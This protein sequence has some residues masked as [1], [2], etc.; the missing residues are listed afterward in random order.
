MIKSGSGTTATPSWTKEQD[1][2]GTLAGCKPQLRRPDGG[3]EIPEAQL[4]ESQKHAELYKENNTTMLNQL[5]SLSVVTSSQAE[6]IK[7]SMEN[8]GAKDLYIQDLQ[9][10]MS[11]KDSLNMA[12]VMN[13]VLALLAT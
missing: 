11:R 9:K 12:L 4:Q 13:L 7:Q 3:Q 10:E 5:Q 6:S 1:H 2:G 8:I